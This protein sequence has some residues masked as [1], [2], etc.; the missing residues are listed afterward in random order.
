MR[1]RRGDASDQSYIQQLCQHRA[2]ST[3]ADMARTGALCTDEISAI[4]TIL[5]CKGCRTSSKKG[6]HA[7]KISHNEFS[8][9]GKTDA[10]MAALQL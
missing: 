6:I 9:P 2:P 4:S 1:M 8:L 3:Q 10:V 5:D 7:I